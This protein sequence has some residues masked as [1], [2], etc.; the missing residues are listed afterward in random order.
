[1]NH[2]DGLARP[3]FKRPTSDAA[4]SGCLDP[5]EAAEK[6]AHLRARIDDARGRE[7]R[8]PLKCDSQEDVEHIFKS[9]LPHCMLK[10]GYFH[11]LLP[12]R[13]LST[14]FLMSEAEN[15]RSNSD[16][17]KLNMHR[18]DFER[19][20]RDPVKDIKGRLCR[21]APMNTFS[22][23]REALE[24]VSVRPDKY[25]YFMGS[26]L[27]LFKSKVKRF[28]TQIE[29]RL[30]PHYKHDIDEPTQQL[31]FALYRP[32]FDAWRPKDVEHLKNPFFDSLEHW[33]TD[34]HQCLLQ[35]FSMRNATYP[36]DVCKL[37][38][39]GSLR[40]G[41]LPF[42]RLL[43]QISFAFDIF[44][45]FGWQH[46]F[47]AW[48]QRT[49]DDGDI[50]GRYETFTDVFSHLSIVGYAVA[51]HTERQHKL[52]GEYLAREGR[53]D[54]FIHES[55]DFFLEEDDEDN[56]VSK[57]VSILL[58][59]YHFAME[60]YK[61][62][63]E[64]L[65]FDTTSDLALINTLE[66]RDPDFDLYQKIDG[67]DYNR[68]WTSLLSTQVSPLHWFIRNGH[69]Q[70]LQV[71]L[72]GAF[73]YL[74]EHAL[75]KV[76]RFYGWLPNS[77]TPMSYARLAV[78]ALGNGRTNHKPGYHTFT[79][80]CAQMM[81]MLYDAGAVDH[82]CSRDSY[83]DQR[84][85]HGES[86]FYE[87]IAADDDDCFQH[88]QKSYRIHRFYGFRPQ[89]LSHF[90]KQGESMEY[91]SRRWSCKSFKKG[92]EKCT[93]NM[94]TEDKLYDKHVMFDCYNTHCI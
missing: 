70:T 26:W 12:L 87:V 29:D 93:L 22:S 17:T 13:F 62:Y 45:C 47:R 54:P 79:L 34:S 74:K 72:D 55:P 76:Y 35:T 14:E 46:E 94:C 43:G 52:N 78:R 91:F 37:N 60:R 16:P 88:N 59:E 65:F 81:W 28:M 20:M 38:P 31:A 92:E 4:L 6:A 57:G 73:P 64:V 2:Q 41:P 89:D 27:P 75:N 7:Q 84:R 85:L 56:W 77:T 15:V 5:S 11:E 53:M 24:Q 68:Y 90:K 33:L 63:P 19:A 83:A 66:Y 58:D 23:V 51:R 86:P 39:D 25:R 61:N 9:E 42:N 18:F 8:A 69:I 67:T 80:K 3:K 49:I 32:G 48:E 50:I 21:G 71:F 82:L 40:C 1:M 44:M 30:C 36:V 10:A